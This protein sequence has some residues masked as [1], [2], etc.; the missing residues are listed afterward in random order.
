MLV[1]AKAKAQQARRSRFAGVGPSAG[2][3]GFCSRR[4][5]ELTGTEIPSHPAMRVTSFALTQGAGT[6]LSEVYARD[7]DQSPPI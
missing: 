6:A 1:C 2:S 3:S 7:D 5:I 4:K